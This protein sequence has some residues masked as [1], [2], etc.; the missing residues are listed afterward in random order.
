MPAPYLA[1]VSFWRLV[2]P[3]LNHKGVHKVMVLSRQLKLLVQCMEK[4]FMLEVLDRTWGQ[5]RPTNEIHTWLQ[6][7]I[8]LSAEKWFNFFPPELRIEGSDNWRRVHDP[9]VNET[10]ARV[11]YL[12]TTSD[13]YDWISESS[14][15]AG[16]AIY[17]KRHGSPGVPLSGCA[18][19][20]ESLQDFAFSTLRVSNPCDV[21]WKRKSIDDIDFVSAMTR[22][23]LILAPE[24]SATA[25][26]VRSWLTDGGFGSPAEVR[27]ELHD[28]WELA[29]EISYGFH[30]LGG[31]EY[32]TLASRWE[33]HLRSSYENF[34]M[35]GKTAFDLS[36]DDVS[37]ASTEATSQCLMD[38]IHDWLVGHEYRILVKVNDLIWTRFF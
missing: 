36:D 2:V 24:A 10:F 33:P 1:S 38:R 35:C 14:L 18:E 17:E 23:R 29:K 22:G 5:F 15:D 3:F 19:F 31:E 12:Y 28:M 20:P 21:H 25:L 34:W 26:L 7:N 32:E 11:K 4:H 8:A 9:D 6:A 16:F 30:S 37:N 13:P 27:R